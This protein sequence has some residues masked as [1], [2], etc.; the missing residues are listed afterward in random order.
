MLRER[1]REIEW[2]RRL[3]FSLD[4]ASSHI[5]LARGLPNEF[6]PLDS[7]RRYKAIQDIL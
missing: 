2:D 7:M 3:K 4:L 1:E 5:V 6:K